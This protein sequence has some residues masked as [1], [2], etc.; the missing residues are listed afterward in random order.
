MPSLSSATLAAAALHLCSGAPVD[1]LFDAPC[2]AVLTEAQ[3]ASAV[4]GW[5]VVAP[6]RGAGVA[7]ALGRDQLRLTGSQAGYVQ[8]LMLSELE[9]A[10]MSEAARAAAGFGAAAAFGQMTAI[11]VDG[12]AAIVLDIRTGPIRIGDLR[13]DPLHMTVTP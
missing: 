6:S 10:A 5:D 2:A 1:R 13:I 12:T 9:L 7:E 3:L 4:G 8:F 11:P